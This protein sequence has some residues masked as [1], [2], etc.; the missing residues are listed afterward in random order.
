MLNLLLKLGS[1][2]SFLSKESRFPLPAHDAVRYYGLWYGLSEDSCDLHVC[3]LLWPE[4]N[5][6]FDVKF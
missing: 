3:A 5:S 1:Q 4:S 6:K 2:L